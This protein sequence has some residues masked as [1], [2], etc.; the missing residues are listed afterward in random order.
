[1]GCRRRGEQN[2]HIFYYLHDGLEHVDRLRVYSLDAGRRD[3]HR[4][5][6]GDSWSR[7]TAKVP[8]LGL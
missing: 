4:Y 7:Q 8:M 2:F 3:K 1:V 6:A 5:L